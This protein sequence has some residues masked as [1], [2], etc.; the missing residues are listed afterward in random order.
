MRAG[1]SRKLSAEELMLL[2]CGIGEDSWESLGLQGDSTSPSQRRSVLGVHWKDRCWSWNSNTLATWY[3]EMTH[4]KR[5]DAGK[6]EGR[7]RREWQRMRWVDSITDSV[8]MDLGKLR[9]LVM[10][11]E[12]W[13]AAVHGVAQSQTWLSDWTEQ[14]IASS[15][16]GK[17]SQKS[18][19]RCLHRGILL[20]V[21]RTIYTN[22][23]TQTIP[24]YWRWGNTPKFSLWGHLHPNTKFRQRHY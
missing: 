20:K 11:R 1:L 16:N 3:E 9:Q 23:F 21:Q 10:D 4:W 6:D 14:E 17:L 8:D 2:N 7:R 12:A 19:T 15:V 24:T 22:P 13:R 18:T 5:T